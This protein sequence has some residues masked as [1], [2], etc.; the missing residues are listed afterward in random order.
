MYVVNRTRVGTHHFAKHRV[1]PSSR[2][3]EYLEAI[4]LSHYHLSPIFADDVV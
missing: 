4:G 3:S 1:L 2:N